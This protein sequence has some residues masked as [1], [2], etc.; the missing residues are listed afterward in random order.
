VRPPRPKSRPRSPHGAPKGLKTAKT[1]TG[2]D[3]VLSGAIAKWLIPSVT[4]LFATVGYLV[5]FAHEQL[6][7][8]AGDRAAGSYVAAAADF[9]RAFPTILYETLSTAS[10]THWHINHPWLVALAT[11]LAVS[12][13]VLQHLPNRFG[14]HL[15]KPPWLSAI[16]AWAPLIALI[17]IVAIKFVALDAPLGAIKDVLLGEGLAGVSAKQTQTGKDEGLPSLAEQ[18]REEVAARIGLLDNSATSARVVVLRRAVI[19]SRVD[20]RSVS[21]TLGALARSDCPEAMATYRDR[22]R[23]EFVVHLWMY[24][25]IVASALGVLAAPRGAVSAGLAILA[26]AYGLTLANAYGKLEKSTEFDYGV[27][28]LSEA[29]QKATPGPTD[30]RLMPDDPGHLDALILSRGSSGLELLA[31]VR[32]TCGGKSKER[33]SRVK[34]TWIAASQVLSIQEI[35]RQDAITWAALNKV[36]CPPAQAPIKMFAP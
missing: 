16:G 10:W 29:L 21:Q 17:L 20:T 30:P 22:L 11:G 12:A 5:Q 27:L 15:I 14:S 2:E 31:V 6:L 7:G 8:V 19:C 25:M 36:K 23:D 13:L 24:A 4:A 26:L 35:Y 9:F 34:H 18:A 32:D 28:R 1:A 33:F 3:G